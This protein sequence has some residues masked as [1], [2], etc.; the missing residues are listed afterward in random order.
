MDWNDLIALIGFGLLV[1]GI[2]MIYVPAAF[3]VAGMILLTVAIFRV[4]AASV[5][6]YKRRRNVED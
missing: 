1:T 2:Y 4:R 5:A 3:V 6:D